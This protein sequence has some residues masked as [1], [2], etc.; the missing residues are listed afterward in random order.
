MN[1]THLRHPNKGSPKDWIAIPGN[2]HLDIYF[3]STNRGI[4]GQRQFG[5]TT[6]LTKKTIQTFRPLREQNR[7]AK[8]KLATGYELLL[9]PSDQ[10]HTG[11]PAQEDPDPAQDPVTLWQQGPSESH[12]DQNQGGTDPM[13]TDTQP[14]PTDIPTVKSLFHESFPPI[15]WPVRPSHEWEKYVPKPTPEYRFRP[16]I[17]ADV[18]G[19]LSFGS[20]SALITG[21]TGSGKS[22]LINEI[23]A[24]SNIPVFPVVGHNRLEWLDLV[25][26]YVP[27]GNG[28]FVYEY[29]PLPNAMKAGGIFLVDELDLIDPSTLVA[30][31]SVLDGRPLV[32]SANNG[33]V[34][35]PA[36][37]FRIIG[38]CNSTCHGDGEAEGY[39]GTL[40]MSKAFLNRL[41]WT[42]IFDYPE[43]EIETEIVEKILG[44]KDVSEKMVG[45]ANEVRRVHMAD[46]APIPDTLSTR[47]LIEWSKAALFFRKVSRVKNPLGYAL[48]TTV[49]NKASKEG[50]PIFAEI[51]QRVFN[52]EL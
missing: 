8:D 24:R 14:L 28:A 50:R 18:L 46:E 30:L 19:W 2:D 33:E 7:R 39:T 31:N 38:T 6:G 22:S 48:K 45:F 44:N 12:T 1:I 36:E 4:K 47:Q 37:G 43:P 34:I 42:F 17:S 11:N 25:G 16:D 5:D 52:Q 3:G 9:A 27:N 21:P 29:G 20:L 10:A 23:A 40:K 49:V 13:T 15:P 32:L 51:F 26:Q 41:S 35:E